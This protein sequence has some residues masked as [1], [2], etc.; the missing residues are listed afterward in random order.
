MKQLSFLPLKIAVMVVSDTRTEQTDTSGKNLITLL[1]D[2]GHFLAEKCIVPD[3]IYE[4]RAVISRWIVDPNVD[5]VISTGG[6]GITGRDGTFEAVL[7]LFDKLIEGFGEIFRW[8]SYNEISTSTIQSRVTA[9][10]VNGK[11]I[12]CLPGSVSACKTGWEKII[13]KQLDIRTKPCNLAELI[14]RLKEK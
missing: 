3:D 1:T 7:P 13:V 12:F 6:T 10:V 14:P 5:I 8:L 4:I 11:Y 2:A 9:G